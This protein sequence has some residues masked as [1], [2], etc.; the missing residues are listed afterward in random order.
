MDSYKRGN[1]NLQ[2]AKKESHVLPS[3][4]NCVLSS[5]LK[6]WYVDFSTKCLT[7]KQWY[8]LMYTQCSQRVNF[9]TEISI[10]QHQ[11][12]VINQCLVHT[13]QNRTL[14]NVSK[15]RWHPSVQNMHHT[16]S[17]VQ[18]NLHRVPTLQTNRLFFD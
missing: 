13:P 2:N 17:S 15:N 14:R 4:E 8:L 10:L 9:N 7:Y 6:P 1:K 3:G 12:P 18:A 11:L 16:F 5:I